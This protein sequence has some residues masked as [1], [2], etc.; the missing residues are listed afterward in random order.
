MEQYTKA[1][2]NKLHLDYNRCLTKYNLTDHPIFMNPF[3]YFFA[4]NLKI[5]LPKHGTDYNHRDFLFSPIPVVNLEYLL[6][7]DEIYAKEILQNSNFSDNIT[8]SQNHFK[9][10]TRELNS[11]G[12]NFASFFNEELCK[13]LYYYLVSNLKIFLETKLL[14]YYKAINIPDIYLEY[15]NSQSHTPTCVNL[16][17]LPHLNYAFKYYLDTGLPSFLYDPLSYFF[18]VNN[19]LYVNTNLLR[20]PQQYKKTYEPVTSDLFISLFQSSSIKEYH[21]T[22]K[23]AYLYYHQA[24]SIQAFKKPNIR[25]AKLLYKLIFDTLQNTPSRNI[26][27]DSFCIRYNKTNISVKCD[28]DREVNLLAYPD[29]PMVLLNCIFD[30]NIDTPLTSI[31]LSTFLTRLFPNATVLNAF[32]Q[33]CSCIYS[34]SYA[35]KAF[36][37]ATKNEELSILQKI[38]DFIS[39][40]G[41][42]SFKM[43]DFKKIGTYTKLKR[44]RVNG[45]NCIIITYTSS[46][47][48]SLS[49]SKSFVDVIAGNMITYKDIWDFQYQNSMPVIILTNRRDI[50]IED[51]K[52]YEIETIDFTNVDLFSMLNTIEEFSE[53]EKHSIVLSLA[54]QGLILGNDIPQSKNLLPPITEIVTNFVNNYCEIGN[55][56]L[57]TPKE[58]L[59][60]HFN[61]YYKKLYGNVYSDTKQGIS[62][63]LKKLYAPKD[64]TVTILEEFKKAIPKG[65]DNPIGTKSAL[66]GFKRIKINHEKLNSFISESIEIEDSNIL[67]E[68]INKIVSTY[69]E[70]L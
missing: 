42:I 65:I 61:E 58:S 32:L 22:L 29:N 62:Q 39:N 36:I 50:N 38:I 28:N 70:S 17:K 2:Q 69:N 30:C 3:Q 35:T 24:T 54:L 21:D 26:D 64:K 41:S 67:P 63:I 46:K 9:I 66:N 1:F 16:F 10:N 47:N 53:Y 13:T 14:P 51:N 34:P 23:G 5:Y 15:D 56:S 68:L 12:K 55:D 19:S 20:L 45:G 18:I 37:I 48:A 52:N 27:I 43:Y 4:Y 8:E 59:N 49:F 40:Q 7:K 6:K 25:Y 11:I 44:H 31:V 60:R 33:I 57:F